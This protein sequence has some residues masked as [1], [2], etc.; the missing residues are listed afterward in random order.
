[1]EKRNANP[2]T[3][4]DTGAEIEAGFLDA[5]S[6]FS[7]MDPAASAQCAD[8]KFKLRRAIMRL[9]PREALA[10]RLR[11]A[12]ESTYAQIGLRLRVS[13][14]SAAGMIETAIGKLRD[15]LDQ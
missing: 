9:S 15:I 8:L 4:P 10:L 2:D 12:Q 5:T 14:G 7:Q 13:S 1:V 3:S 6:I 11:F